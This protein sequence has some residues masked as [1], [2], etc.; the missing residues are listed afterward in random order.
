MKP[1]LDQKKSRQASVLIIVLWVAFG[2]VSI[3]LYFAHAMLMD[4]KAADNRSA[5]FE[6]DQAIEGAAL[7]VSNVLANR[8]NM[9]VIPSA[10]NFKAE[11]VKIG[12][13]KFWLIGRDTNDLQTSLQ[14]ETPF[15]GLVDEAGKVNLNHTA[16]TNFQNL[17]GMTQNTAAAMSD[18]ETTSTTPSTGGAKSETYSALQTPYLCKDAPYETIEELR[19]VFGLSMDLLYGEDAN[20]NG[21]L[22][23][24]ENDGMKVPP[25]DN[26]NGILDP[27]VFE[28]VT[29]W[30]QESSLGTNNITRVSV[31]NT[32]A[33]QSLF[34]TNFPNLTQYLTPFTS[35]TGGT[36]SSGTGGRG[37]GGGSSASTGG[38]A[39][40]AA[41]APTSVLDFYV[42]SG[43]S[44]TDF[45]QVEPYLM[46]PSLAGLINIDTASA[47]A[48]A[49]VPGI[50]LTMAPQ[51]L[52]YR[53]SNPPQVP[54]IVWLAAALNNNQAALEA[55]GPYVTPFSF[56]F[57]ADVVAVGHNN[58]GFRRV[59]FVFD[60]S[61]G[62]PLIVYR[63]DLTYLGWP[64]GKKL[65]DQLLA[66]N[67]K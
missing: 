56:Q 45:E 13:A 11:G 67:T 2:L 65:H 42:R 12:D 49:C 47:T 4:L 55:A 41:S 24:N 60:C 59:R 31:T 14:S 61:S 6:A 17:P 19:M 1:R 37:T 51:V 36:G 27:G 25:Y 28:Y 26:Q 54:S 52:S 58:R 34:A 16:A 46:N 9:M 57:A 18:W 8:A 48:L 3:T 33:L 5:N 39:A 22:D 53:Q 63:Q 32:T 64:L 66:Q 50:G 43:M 40:A 35:G 7:Y 38:A 23:P 30:S 10:A 21:A 44:Q 29:T 20:L 15:W 62:T